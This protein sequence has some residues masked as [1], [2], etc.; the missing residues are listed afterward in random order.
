M[1]ER[2]GESGIMLMRDSHTAEVKNGNMLCL[3]CADEGFL[4]WE[5]REQTC[6]DEE[7]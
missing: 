4:L 5:D 3:C 6:E 2:E 7:T 1:N